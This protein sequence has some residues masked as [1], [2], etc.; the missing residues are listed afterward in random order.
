MRLALGY[1][2]LA[3]EAQDAR[4]ADARRRRSSRSIPWRGADEVI[5]LAERAREVFVEDSLSRY[6]VA[7]LRQ[8]RSDS[9]LYLGASPRSGI[10]L[11]RVAKARALADG[12]DYLVPDDVKAVAVPRALAP[13]DPRPRGALCRARRRG[14]RRRGARED[15]RPRMT[16]RGRAVAR[17]GRRRLCRGLDL[18]LARRSIRSRP[19]SSSP[20]SLAVGW[21]R[22]SS[23]PPHVSRHGAARD[24]VEGDDVRIGLEVETTS[25]VPPPTL[26]AHERPGSLGERRVELASRGARRHSRAAT[27]STRVP[28]G[29][30]A[31]DAVRLTIEDPFALAR[32]ELVQG[33]P[34]ALVVYPRLVAARPALLRGRRARAGG[35]AAA[36]PAP[37]GVRAAQRA[38][39]RPR[40][41]APQGALALDRAARAADGE[42]ARGRS[43]RRGRG[44]ARRRRR[45]ATAG[46]SFDV[47]V[48]AAGSILQA[49]HR[50]GRRCALVVNSAARET[51]AIAT[52]ANWRRAL[53]ILAGAEPTARTPAYALLQADGGIA[54]RSLELVVVTSRVD[55]PLVDRLVQRALSRRGVSLVYVEAAARPAA[56]AAAAPG[57]RDSRRRRA[58]RRRSRGRARR[59]GGARCVGRPSSRSCRP[60]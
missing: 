42:G 12:R 21:V 55:V 22:L 53:E 18:R 52:D 45:G 44:A 15:T 10:A 58:G 4:R 6:V 24:L 28:R 31:F 2:S 26:V 29:R 30:Y 13:A 57:G 7:L 25:A 34:Q 48:R 16:S 59:A 9:R 19:G 35:A 41:L 14:D 49:H 5:R 38:R 33:E 32:A 40:R 43:A 60:S 54:A 51:Q 3:E 46:D 17:S 50:R 56:A 36:A 11:L 23:R 47:A 1:P 20:S 39:L 8:T 27:S 37:D